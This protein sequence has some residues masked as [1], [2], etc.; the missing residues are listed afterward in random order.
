M[1]QNIGEAPDRYNITVTDV[2]GWADVSG[3]PLQTEIVNA[4]SSTVI[5]VPV[6]VPLLANRSLSDLITV[7]I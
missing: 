7:E 2:L 1:I 6:T 3:I 4:S 5:V